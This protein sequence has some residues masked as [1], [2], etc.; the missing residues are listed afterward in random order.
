MSDSRATIDALSR[1]LTVLNRSLPMYLADAAPWTAPNSARATEVL[2]NIVRDQR[3]LAARVGELI[4]DRRGEISLGPLPDY[5]N[6]ADLDIGFL[7]GRLVER[8]QG[9]VE[10]IGQV[11][12]DLSADDE[13]RALAEEALGAARAHLEM[14]EELQRAPAAA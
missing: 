9:D 8:Q 14:L 11:V 1:L 4:Y 6:L 10:A 12:R 5:T 7:V 2:A 13:A 3:D